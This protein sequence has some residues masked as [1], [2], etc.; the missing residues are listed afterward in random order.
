MPGM[1]GVIV[2]WCGKLP[3]RLANAPIGLTL[4]AVPVAGSTVLS[5]DDS[6]LCDLIGVFGIGSV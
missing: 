4:Q 3:V 5:V 1:S 2:W 6:T